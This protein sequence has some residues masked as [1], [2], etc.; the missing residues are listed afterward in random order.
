MNEIDR[1][2]IKDLSDN[3]VSLKS[4]KEGYNELPSSK[5]SSI[6]DTEFEVIKNTAIK[7]N[8]KMTFS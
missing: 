1:D 8:Y 4:K 3:D 5:K 2:S 6:L 7:M